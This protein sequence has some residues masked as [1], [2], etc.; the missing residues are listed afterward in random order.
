M[1]EIKNLQQH[2]IWIF[3]TLVQAPN[4]PRKLRF[5][6]DLELVSFIKVNCKISTSSKWAG[7]ASLEK[8]FPF[9]LSEITWC[10]FIPSSKVFSKYIPRS[11]HC[12]CIFQIS[13]KSLKFYLIARNSFRTLALW[14]IACECAD[15]NNIKGY[16]AEMTNIGYVFHSL[17]SAFCCLPS[18]LCTPSSSLSAFCPYLPLFVLHPPPLFPS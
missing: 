16:L 17:S 11:C 2:W 8:C 7:Y 13:F 4:I 15:N 5:F 18:T 12:L 3:N 9:F 1:R 10:G 6:S 14:W